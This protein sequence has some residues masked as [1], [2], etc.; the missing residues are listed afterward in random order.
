MPKKRA[1]IPL[2]EHSDTVDLPSRKP[3]AETAFER[4]SQAIRN[5]TFKPGQRIL[6]SDIAD[7]L[8]MSRTPVREALR[9]LVDN[10]LLSYD[11]YGSLVVTEFT[12]Q[13][14]IEIYTMRIILESAGARLAAQYAYKEEIEALR[15]I[16]ES[17]KNQDIDLWERVRLNRLYRGTIIQ[18]SHNHYLVRAFNALPKPVRPPIAVGYDSQE[19]VAT[20]ISEYER[21]TNAIANRNPSEAEAASRAHIEAS[22]HYW[23]SMLNKA[24]S[25]E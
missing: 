14:V 23:L 16:M 3:L 7:W 25:E 19:R 2:S 9:R 17:F 6:E 18:A 10:D 11:R 15:G 20:I 21:L 5:N 1:V 24:A 13:M 12:R 4:L 22:Q 8:N